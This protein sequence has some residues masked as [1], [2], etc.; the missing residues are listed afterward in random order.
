MVQTTPSSIGA[1]IDYW[2]AAF[3][4]AFAADPTTYVIDGPIGG[5][6]IDA[7]Q[8]IVAI[9]ADVVDDGG[10][11]N[12]GARGD[13]AWRW[14]GA[15]ARTET[16]EIPCFVL[17]AD[18]SSLKTCRDRCLAVMAQVIGL[19]QADLSSGGL[20][21]TSTTVTGQDFQQQANSSGWQCHFH[22]VI[23]VSNIIR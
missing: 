5:L 3:T 13:Q 18:G 8:A 4:T 21:T 22:F 20:V 12:Q 6:E 14:I 16:Y 10:D 2:V 17:T 23:A 19:L 11:D 9:G 1:V 15:R 7:Y